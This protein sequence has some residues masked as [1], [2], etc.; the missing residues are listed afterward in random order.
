MLSWFQEICR[1]TK[2]SDV[3]SKKFFLRDVIAVFIKC[4]KDEFENTLTMRNIDDP[5]D[6]TSDSKTDGVLKATDFH[7][8]ITVPAIWSASG[9]QMMREAAYQVNNLFFKFF[10]VLYYKPPDHS[11]T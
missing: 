1:D 8:V 4:L 6:H 9:K 10:S 5:T 7:W 11:Q 3:N 2:I